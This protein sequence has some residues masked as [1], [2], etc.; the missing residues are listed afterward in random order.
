VRAF[1][2]AYGWA[3]LLKLAEELRLCDDGDARRWSG[4]LAPLAAAFVERYLE[5]LPKAHYP[6]RHGV[7]A[8]SAFGV[9]FALDY[10]RTAGAGEL[11]SLCKKTAT[12]WF[13]SDR[14]APAAWEPS[15]ADF[16]SSAL[17]EADLMRRVLDARAFGV[18]LERFLPGI[19]AREPA[20]L[21]TPAVV[22]DRLDPQIVHLDGL[23]LS[24]AWCFRGIAAA[25]PQGDARIAVALRAADVHLAAG[26][27]GMERA[28]YLGSHWLASFAAL[29][30]GEAPSQRLT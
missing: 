25:L 19:A 1:E 28:D 8:N 16:L 21:F 27:A 4:A 15:G 18:W 12:G 14:D 20:T 6:I 11:E 17:I 9:A 30:L 3:W 24:R 29:A 5:Y 22:T 23:A 13:A 26:L 7:H 2:R 10:A